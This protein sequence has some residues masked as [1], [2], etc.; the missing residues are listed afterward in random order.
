M[1]LISQS[2]L[3]GELQAS[4]RIKEG[5][6]RFSPGL[7]TLVHLN[8]PACTH[9]HSHALTLLCLYAN[10]GSTYQRAAPT[11]TGHAPTPEASV[12]SSWG[13]WRGLKTADAR[14]PSDGLEKTSKPAKRGGILWR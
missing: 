2:S 10:W 13:V 1:S 8:K 6:Q 5:L 12:G 14:I 9:T 3:L 4:D 7:H 11:W